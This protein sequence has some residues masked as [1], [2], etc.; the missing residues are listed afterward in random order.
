MNN[1]QSLTDSTST[2]RLSDNEL[3]AVSLRAYDNV[4]CLVLVSY[5]NI[6]ILSPQIKAL[7]PAHGTRSWGGLCPHPRWPPS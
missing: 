2:P 3:L 6:A 5:E 4:L 1:S 7:Y